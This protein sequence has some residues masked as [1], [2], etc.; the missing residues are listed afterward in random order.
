MTQSGEMKTPAP[1][2]VGSG[3]LMVDAPV[4]MFHVLFAVCFFGAWATSERDSWLSLHVTFGYS[5]AGLLLFRIAYGLFGP[6]QARLSSL[7]GR[8]KGLLNIFSGTGEAQTN[9]NSMLGALQNASMAAATLILFILTAVACASGYLTWN[10]WPWWMEEVHEEIGE[11]LI[12]VGVIHM[13][14]VLGFSIIRRRNL[15]LTM[16][17]GRIAGPGPSIVRHNRAWLAAVM[18]IAV[19]AFAAYDAQQKP[20]GYFT[21]RISARAFKKGHKRE[22]SDWQERREERHRRDHSR[23]KHEYYD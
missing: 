21:D 19:C 2:S 14:L 5:M 3:R 16:L 17:T 9:R 23:R 12:A 20:E 7:F 4:R 18:L 13:V 6:S 22:Y 11:A 1:E 8:I 15:A 10:D